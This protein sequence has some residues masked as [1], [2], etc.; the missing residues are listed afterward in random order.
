MF[1]PTET[2]TRFNEIAELNHMT[3]RKHGLVGV[4]FYIPL[5]TLEQIQN[6]KGKNQSEKIR[7]LI[8]KGLRYA[9]TETPE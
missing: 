3:N 4:T 7:L 9:E 6:L 2:H 5:K 8:Q 1:T